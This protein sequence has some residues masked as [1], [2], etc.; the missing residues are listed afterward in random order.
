MRGTRSLTG[1]RGLVLRR[2]VLLGLLLL[3]PGCPDWD[4]L[5]AGAVV[6]ATA[7]QATADRGELGLDLWPDLGP[8]LDLGPAP[9]GTACKASSKPS[10]CPAGALLCDGFEGATIGS[11]WGQGQQG[12]GTFTLDS[13][14]LFRGKGSVLLN[15]PAASTKD[16]N[17]AA[18]LLYPAP[19]ATSTVIKDHLKTMGNTLFLRAHVYLEG[20][21]L[22][23][24][25]TTFLLV[26]QANP[27]WC[28]AGIRLQMIGKKL[29]IKN[30]L[31]KFTYTPSASPMPT[32]RWTC[33]ELAVTSGAPGKVQV[34][35]D[36]VM[37]LDLDQTTT[38][39]PTDMACPNPMDAIRVGIIQLKSPQPAHR[40]WVD[41]V[42][43][44]T[45]LIG[46][47]L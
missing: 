33:L 34:Y 19:L 25:N 11:E 47:H 21:S 14:C 38:P 23:N 32:D 24:Q 41:E 26:K 13:T 4:A 27:E 18:G 10:S 6:D 30:S 12:G 29:G 36:G 17:I 22:T 40:M 3:A 43:V 5:S 39:D 8:P 45:K 46:C 20:D 35:R 1:R 37:I 7:D 2:L 9:D 15:T 44:D 16:Q 31:R 28:S 42:V